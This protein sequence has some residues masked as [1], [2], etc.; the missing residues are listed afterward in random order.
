MISL[1]M[2]HQ[3]IQEVGSHYVICNDTKFTAG[4]VI[5]LLAKKPWQKYFDKN[6]TSYIQKYKVKTNAN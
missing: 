3:M 4:E 1:D 6:N 5:F 2:S